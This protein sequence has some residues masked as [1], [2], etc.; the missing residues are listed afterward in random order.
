MRVFLTGASG[1]IGMAILRELVRSGYDVTCLAREKS[2]AK[3]EALG[4]PGVTVL[5]GD[6]TRIG[7]WQEL[8]RNHDVVINSVGIIRETPNSRFE[9]VHTKAPVALFEAAKEVGVSKIIQISALGADDEAGS[10]YHLSK[11]EADQHLTKLGVP[12]V[13]LRPSFVYGP[14]D[15]SVTFFQSLAALPIT[16]VPGDGQYQVQPVFIDD[17]VRAVVLSIEK[18]ELSDVTIDVGGKTAI[19]FD[20]LL[21]TLARNL[22]KRQAQKVHVPWWIMKAGANLTDLLGRGPINNEELGMLRRGNSCDITPFVERFGFEPIAFQTGVARKS[23]NRADR[24]YARLTHLQIPLRL[25]VAFIWLATGIISAFVSTEMGFQL[26]R[27]IG[28]TGTPA[29]VALYGTSWFEIAIGLAT[30]VGWRVRLM[31][32]IQILLILGFTLI[33][34]LTDPANW[35]LHPFGPLTKNIP[36]LGATLVML[37]MEK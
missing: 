4:L 2:K 14:N 30:A 13:I 35:W 19:T 17:L 1:F 22:E 6:F 27:D 9:D 3:I 37:A 12:Y 31:G 25:T 32:W 26:L 15:H 16:L 33:L 5:A 36:L 20:E 18:Q 28:I 7:N 11:R 10:R 29:T 23:L 24:W 21:D 34:S 8:I